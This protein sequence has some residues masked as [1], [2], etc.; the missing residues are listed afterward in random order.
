[1]EVNA[2]PGHPMWSVSVSYLATT[3][4]NEVNS[5]GLSPD[6]RVYEIEPTVI[7]PKGGS[8]VCPR[9]GG[10]GTA[11]V[12]AVSG[13][14]GG[15]VARLM[16]SYTWG[17]KVQS[18]I[19]DT[20]MDYCKSASLDP[21]ETYIW[22]CCLCVNQHRVIEARKAGE[23]VP[24]EVFHHTF[25]SRVASVET[26]VAV[27]AP[28]DSPNYL[29]RV[30][31]DFEMFTALDLQKHVVIAMPPLETANL[32]DAFMTGDVRTSQE[33]WEVLSGVDV[34]KA[35]ASQPSD[36]DAIF[37]LIE[38]GPGF[39][40]LNSRIV[41]RVK[42]WIITTCEADLRNCIDAGQMPKE[43]CAVFCES[44]V[45]L[46]RMFGLHER[47]IAI[48]DEGLELRKQ[49][50]TLGT[51]GH[52]SLLDNKGL[53]LSGLSDRLDDAVQ[54]LEQAV[55]VYANLPPCR[56]YAD[57]LRN[58]ANNKAKQLGTFDGEMKMYQEAHDVYVQTG[59]L[60]TINGA[61]TLRTW[62][63]AC[64]KQGDLEKA[65]ELYRSAHEVYKHIGATQTPG[66]A[67]LLRAMGIAESKRGN[68]EDALK[69]YHSAHGVYA[70]TGTLETRWGQECVE[71]RTEL[72]GKLSVPDA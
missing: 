43:K 64:D 5:A 4:L 20:L 47:A 44:V 62:A 8:L 1:M 59:T 39:D 26:I 13:E 53:A 55:E 12:D 33:F 46:L 35:E 11:Y 45:T 24:F 50:S 18:E 70:A 71:L 31:C 65:M 40:E 58:L 15:G 56:D 69:L 68:L 36:K 19:V 9:D 21:Q 29:K 28:W 25:A 10:M 72:M 52:G 7:R 48:C 27:M 41:K 3:F 30:W 67:H 63:Q 57:A 38:D 66:C 23:V 34:R 42:S 6:S 22:I 54:S 14:V 51:Y 32:R 61:A 2:A 16:L 17:Y 60:Q 49:S 37:Q